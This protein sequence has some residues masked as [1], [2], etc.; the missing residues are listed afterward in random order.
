M[1]FTYFS[2]LFQESLSWIR[3]IYEIYEFRSW[4]RDWGI[5]IK[6]SVHCILQF[7]WLPSS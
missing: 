1:N 6:P 2:S 4:N 5:E 7:L 3:K